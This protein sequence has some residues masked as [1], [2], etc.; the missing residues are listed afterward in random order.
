MRAEL[1]MK[2]LKKLRN[3][4]EQ[5]M[6]LT[7]KICR[8]LGPAD[9]SADRMSSLIL[10]PDHAKEINLLVHLCRRAYELTEYP[11]ECQSSDGQAAL[12]G[13]TAAIFASV[14]RRVFFFLQS[15]PQLQQLEESSQMSLL[16]ERGMESL[17]IM[18]ALTFDPIGRK[19]ASKDRTS[20]NTLINEPCPIHVGERDFERLHGTSVMRKHFDTITSLLLS[21]NV[22]EQI[23]V[24][25]ALVAF[26]AIDD[27][28]HGNSA[29]AAQILVIQEHF[30]EL[31]KRY[32]HWKMGPE[33]SEKVFAR[34]ILKL[35]DVREVHNLHKV[36][37]LSN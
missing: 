34:Y 7:Q 5:L 11:K 21:L 31:L 26:F 24:L 20:Y 30:I 32:V 9:R 12:P 14:I 19:W 16:K 36:R 22:D 2:S 23:L 13:H 17:I 3:N 6:I 27:H 35:S 28:Q 10:S 33:I 25:L 8:Q 29:E 15:V 1:K 18:S 4:Q 37:R